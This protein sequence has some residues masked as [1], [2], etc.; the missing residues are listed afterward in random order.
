M[1][2]MFFLTVN[3]LISEF[4]K[5]FYAF[6]HR[7]KLTHTNVPFATLILTGKGKRDIPRSNTKTE[8]HLKHS[9]ISKIKLF[10]KN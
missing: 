6:Y 2:K 9:R 4:I 10:A 8:A 3:S 7:V 1:K 5:F